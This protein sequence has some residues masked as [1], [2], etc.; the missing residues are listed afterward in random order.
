MTP[1][2]LQGLQHCPDKRV[3]G[4]VAAALAAME[5]ADALELRVRELE[6]EKAAAEL[7]K[8]GRILIV[9]HRD[10]FVEVWAHDWMPVKV[11]NMPDLGSGSEEEAEGYM[12]KRLPMPFRELYEKHGKRIVAGSCKG[13][14]DR[15]SFRLL[16]HEIAAVKALNALQE[17]LSAEPTVVG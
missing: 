16:Q 4:A 9:L 10:G 5:R 1:K 7:A 3:S 2:Q 14:M 13:C 6:E 11:A 17:T 15:T 12:L 8:E